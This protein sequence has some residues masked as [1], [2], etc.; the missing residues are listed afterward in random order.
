LIHGWSGFARKVLKAST[1]FLREENV[2]P[3]K[4][5]R[6]KENLYKRGSALRRCAFA[7]EIFFLYIL[8]VQSRLELLIVQKQSSAAGK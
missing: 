2:S 6:R 4:A 1:I 3:A 5:Q 8:F 7:G